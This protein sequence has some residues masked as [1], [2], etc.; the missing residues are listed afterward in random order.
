MCKFSDRLSRGLTVAAKWARHFL[1]SYRAK[2]AVMHVSM[3]VSATC[4]KLAE[5]LGNPQCVST[6]HISRA[7]PYHFFSFL[8]EICVEP[9][10]IC[11]ALERSWV[12]LRDVI[13]TQCY[14]TRIKFFRVEALKDEHNTRYILIK[15]V[16]QTN[17][18]SLDAIFLSL[19]LLRILEWSLPFAESS[20]LFEPRLLIDDV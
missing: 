18:N 15:R 10:L 8:I 2:A 17:F 4:F 12:V 3:C 5:L 9:A 1:I 11:Y 6:W 19:K 7:W 13:K 20:C 16:I 14:K